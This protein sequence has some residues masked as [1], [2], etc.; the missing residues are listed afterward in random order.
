MRKW[1]GLI[2]IFLLS[3]MCSPAQAQLLIEQ[4][5]IQPNIIAGETQRGTVAVHNTSDK[6]IEVRAYWE[7]FEYV[8]PFDGKKKF[9]PPGTSPY[10]A[11]DW[12]SFSPREFTLPPFGKIDLTYILNVP[13]TAKGGRYGVLFVEQALGNMPNKTGV[14]IVAR[15]GALFFLETK[16]VRYS[17]VEDIKSDGADLNGVFINAGNLFL[18]PE[19]VY[20]FL[21]A[22]GMVA[23]RGK[24]DKFYISPE[25]QKRFSI[26]IPQDLSPGTYSCVLTFDLGEGHSIVKEIAFSRNTDSSVTL[27]TKPQ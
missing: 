26:S 19:A 20:Y 1:G 23:A 17:K 5:K 15:V 18:T 25:Q 13:R 24:V 7:D 21:D 12:V 14:K 10:S 8:E 16:K 22:Q 11:Y 9:M 27:L 3:F 4:G 6:T 2:I